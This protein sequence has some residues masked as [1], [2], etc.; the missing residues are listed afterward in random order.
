[1]DQ[2]NTDKS[3]QIQTYGCKVN[4]YDSGLLEKR[5][6]AVGYRK[7]KN[8]NVYILNTCAVT[9]AATK[10]AAK[11]ARKIKSKNPFGMVVVTGCGAQVDTEVFEK[12]PAVDL[13]VANSHK[14]QLENLIED[15]YKGKLESKVFK[16]N[17]FNTESNR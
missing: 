7:G 16:S 2:L 15:F 13:V 3:Y 17:I 12:M 10:E 6:E 11:Q 9:E 4:T 1:M 5:F 8:P 14:G